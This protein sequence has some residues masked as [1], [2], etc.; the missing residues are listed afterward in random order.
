MDID[1]QSWFW[2]CLL[3]LPVYPNT[4]Q[5]RLQTFSWRAFLRY[6]PSPHYTNTWL[7]LAAPSWWKSCW[8]GL[9]LFGFEGV[10]HKLEISLLKIGLFTPSCRSLHARLQVHN[11]FVRVGMLRQWAPETEG[12][13]VLGDGCCRAENCNNHMQKQQENDTSKDSVV[14]LC[15]VIM[16][17]TVIVLTWRVSKHDEENKSNIRLTSSIFPFICLW[18]LLLHRLN[19]LEIL[20]ISFCL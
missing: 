3:S 8:L 17:T 7:R 11:F 9:T 18:L 4:A 5:L 15:T 1:L 2:S 19:A 6:P 10:E 13:S 14:G 16:N 12:C 20:L